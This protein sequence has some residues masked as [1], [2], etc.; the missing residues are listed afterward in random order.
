[1]NAISITRTDTPEQGTRFHAKAARSGQ[2]SIGRTMGE[3]LDALTTQLDFTPYDSLFFVAEMKPDKFFTAEQIDRLY[4]LRAKL[5]NDTLTESEN[6][7]FTALV[8]AEL[9][10]S[11]QRIATI[12]DALA[13]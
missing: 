8:E 9:L 12:S 4:Q 7:E 11:A 6:V 5:E 10:G 2:Q 1:M 3:A 13:E